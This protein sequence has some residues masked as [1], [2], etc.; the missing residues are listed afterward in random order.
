MKFLKYG[1]IV[2]V[3]LILIGVGAFAFLGMQS[4]SGSALG[5]VDGQLAA[6][7]SSPNCVS[8]EAGTSEDKQVSAFP[9]TA[10]QALPIAITNMGGDLMTQ[11]DTYLTAEFSSSLFGFVDDLEFRLTDTEIHVRSASRVGHSDAGVNADRVAALRE[12]VVD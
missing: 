11:Q 8:S 3:A 10:W 5:L 6:C 12:A 7:P 4:R 2:I 9:R 1:M